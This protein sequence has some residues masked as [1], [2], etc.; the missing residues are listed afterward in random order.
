[1]TT[2]PAPKARRAPN[3]IN[4]VDERFGLE[5]VGMMLSTRYSPRNRWV[6]AIA[7]P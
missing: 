2:N 4:E 5:P 6:G 3:A 7:L 1:M